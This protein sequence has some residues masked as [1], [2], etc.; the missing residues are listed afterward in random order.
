[1]ANLEY[2]IL[3]VIEEITD[4]TVS[5]NK[6]HDYVKLFLLSLS[7]FNHN[8]DF[9]KSSKSY[10]NNMVDVYLEIE[11]LIKN[12][13]L[14]SDLDKTKILYSNL[15]KT[16]ISI[17]KESSSY[18]KYLKDK[19]SISN[20]LSLVSIEKNPFCDDDESTEEDDELDNESIEEDSDDEG[21][22]ED[23]ELDQDC[24]YYIVK[25]FS[26]D[27]NY[28]VRTDLKKCSC[29]SFEYCNFDIPTC[30]HIKLLEKCSEDEL[31]SY[32][33]TE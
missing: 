12:E 14:Y 27:D 33:K 18:I 9:S 7:F 5:I 29:K 6:I 20:L 19:K 3:S 16:K 30:K 24:Q 13:T 1:M 10:L 32:P 22:E 21:S 8:D 25:S 11:K 17:N 23:D 31:L 28:F 26:N 15:K 2:F 4:D